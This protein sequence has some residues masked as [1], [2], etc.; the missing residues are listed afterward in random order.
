M[1][2]ARRTTLLMVTGALFL[3]ASFSA[4]RAAAPRCAHVVVLTLPG[5][6][7][8]A[9]E[10]AQSPTLLAMAQQGAV[11]SV[12]VRT[13]APRTSYA[14]G[15]A[16]LGAGARVDAPAISGAP[17]TASR[18]TRKGPLLDSGVITSGVA[19]MKDRAEEAGYNARPGALASTL[20]STPVVAVG[21]ADGELP[22]PIPVGYRRWTLL[23][24][25]ATDG[26]VRLSGTDRGLLA[27]RAGAPF[28]VVTDQGALRAAVDEALRIPCSVVFVDQGDVGRADAAALVQPD[29]Y[30]PGFDRLWAL[31]RTDDLVAHVR[32]SL[33]FDRDLLL[34]VSPTSPAESDEPHLG[35]A[36]AQGAGFPPGSTLRSATTRRNGL[37]TLP[38]VAPTVLGHLGRSTPAS[39]TGNRWLAVGGGGSG[40]P[41]RE[42]VELDSETVF[43]DRL[44]APTA[45]AF[46]VAQVLVYGALLPFIARRRE[47]GAGARIAELAALAFV[48]FPA[49]SYLVGVL[50]THSLGVGGFVAALLAVDAALVAATMWLVSG[51]LRRLLALAGVTLVALVLDLVLGAPLQ[52]NAVL[53]YSPT[54]AGRFAGLGNIAFA[55]LG[56]CVVLVGGLIVHFQG[57]SRVSLVAAAAVFAFA[58]IVVGA[59]QLGGDVGGTLALVP[60]L[61][62]CWILLAGRRPTPRALAV[63]A[64]A[65]VAAV[66]LFL[67]IDL[68][69]PVG[70]R[71]HLA[72]LYE[73]VSEG[74]GSVLFDTVARKARSNLDVFRSSIYTLFVPPALGVM[75]WLLFRPPGRWQRLARDLPQ[76]RASLAGG[77]LLAVLGFA[78]NDSGIVIPAVV[79]SYL[80]PLTVLVHLAL[81]RQRLE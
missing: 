21:N 72:R 79:L 46:V 76:L 66:G 19:E 37:V 33:D 30:D 80:V 44:K 49:A 9:V 55:V 22:P 53:G 35:V 58:V 16:S 74:G 78:V 12:S 24:A 13:N 40:D 67:A 59:P 10:R 63:A 8:G 50:S 45:T 75:A 47:E 14:S 68:S 51:A 48:A 64:L 42:A 7:W 69:R 1:R 29:G 54:V 31:Q 71:T 4:A 70:S 77:L 5:V 61:G 3:G 81:N 2:A 18:P 73:D 41:V 34:V 38:D 62:M 6:T 20:A 32:D 57:G 25:M 11:G 43:V 56:A 28:G 36:A 23:A 17:A 26:R 52:L 65:G 39:M 27:E 15:F 60:A